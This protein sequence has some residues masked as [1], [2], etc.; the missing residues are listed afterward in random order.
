MTPEALDQLEQAANLAKRSASTFQRYVN[1]ENFAQLASPDAIL[2]LIADYRK[3]VRDVER[4]SR[5]GSCASL[6]PEHEEGCFYRVA[7]VRP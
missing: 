6:L 1:E 4:L 7:E 2:A 3:A 5:C